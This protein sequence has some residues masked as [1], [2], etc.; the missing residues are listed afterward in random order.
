MNPD[1]NALNRTFFIGGPPRVGKS[2]IS[3]LLAE[4]IK[5]HVTSTDAIRNAVKKIPNSKTGPLFGVNELGQ[6]PPE[7]WLDTHF[8]HP[9]TVVNIQ[10]E[11]S[12]A[13]WDSIVSY[14]SAFCEDDVMHIMEGVAILPKLVDTMRYKPKNV[15]FVGN[16]SNNHF[17]S[18]L[19]HAREN[20]ERDW[21]SAMGYD[22]KKIKAMSVFVKKMSE[23]FKDEAAKYGFKYYEID[24]SHF[25]Q[26]IAGIVADIARFDTD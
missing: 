20:P 26:S 7:K 8:N 25:Q 2:L 11:E 24:D 4:S 21:M 9:D 1:N 3:Y 23:Y 10:N 15:F 19:K 14:A 13:Y 22:E 6:Y 12:K 18:I 17:E 16:T 5:G